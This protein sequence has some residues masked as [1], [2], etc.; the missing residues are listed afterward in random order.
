MNG[1]YDSDPALPASN[2]Q[3]ADD[4]E[5]AGSI[6]D[7]SDVAVDASAIADGTYERAWARAWVATCP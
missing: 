6:L 2:G 5:A 3:T 7:A 1:V 4:G